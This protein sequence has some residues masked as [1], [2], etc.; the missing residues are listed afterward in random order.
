[1]QKAQ[2]NTQPCELRAASCAGQVGTRPRHIR[3]GRVPGQVG[4][5]PW[6]IRAGVSPGQVSLELLAILGV[7]LIVILFFTL[8]A[9]DMLADTNKQ[10]ELR[11][12]RLSVQHLAD[13]ADYVFSQGEGAAKTVEVE[14]SPNANLSADRSF[15]GKPYSAPENASSNM[16]NINLE[17]S[18][19]SAF[20]GAP[21][22]GAFPSAHGKYLLKVVSRGSFVSIGSNLLSASPSSISISMARSSQKRVYL[23]LTSLSGQPVAINVTLQWQHS[24]PTIAASPPKLVLYSGAGQVALTFSSD[25][26]DAGIYS[27]KLLVSSSQAGSGMQPQETFSIP[28]TAE[29]AA[30]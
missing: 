4:T 9:S 30:G 18:D 15:I 25:A 5:S 14:L 17:G 10:Q 1:M 28:I 3:A 6:R 2:V 7:A 13:A 16:I 26:T 29:V 22:A 19:V 12:A 20:S 11:T 27:G 23:N 8:F 21:L 24:S